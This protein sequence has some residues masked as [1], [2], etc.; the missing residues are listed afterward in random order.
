MMSSLP[1][2]VDQRGA[3]TCAET[4]INF[5]ILSLLPDVVAEFSTV[6]TTPSRSVTVTR[7]AIVRNPSS[8]MAVNPIASAVR[9]IPDTAA[10]A[11][12][13]MTPA[14]ALSAIS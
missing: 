3:N 5:A 1:F 6:F 11:V 10:P 2:V 9:V 8:K 4:S 12:R 7:A 13:A 14:A